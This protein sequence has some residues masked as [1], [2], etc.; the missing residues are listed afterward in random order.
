VYFLL[1]RNF[2]QIGL[3]LKN[4]VWP[5]IFHC[6]EHV[7]FIIQDFLATCACPEKQSCPGIFHC[8]E[9]Y[10]T[11]Q[12]F[13]Q[14]AVALKNRVVLKIFILLNIIFTCNFR[15]DH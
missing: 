4:R 7:F 3:T 13:E 1:F 14:L 11:I 6:I 8:S 12:D 10:F 2:E 5:G 9:I 15:D